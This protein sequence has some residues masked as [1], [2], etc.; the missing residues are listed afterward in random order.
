MSARRSIILPL[1]VFIVSGFSGYAHADV[2]AQ[3]VASV[4]GEKIS[5][6]ELR[7]AIGFWGGGVSASDIPAEKKTETLERLITGRL[8]SQ[9]ARSRGLDN[10]EEFRNMLRQGEHNRMISAMFR[11]EFASG[12]KITKEE[13]RAESAKLRKSDK[14]LTP[15]NANLKAKATLWKRKTQKVQEGLVD[16]AKKHS[17]AKIIEEMIENIAKGE[18]VEDNAVL[19]IVGEDNVSYGEFKKAMGAMAG[20]KHA[21]TDISANPDAIRNFLNREITGRSLVVY[22]RAQ[23][24]EDSEWMRLVRREAERSILTDM[25]MKEKILN[26]VDVTEKE[27]QDAYSKHAQMMVRDGKKIPL[28][29]VKGQIRDIVMQE[30]KKKAVDTY[31]AK[32]KKKAKIT[33]NKKLLPKV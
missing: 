7:E 28:S 21:G 12:V 22:A 10:T 23:R 24:I 30:K 4:N 8:L 9:D 18:K 32:L 33:V 19:A 25:L 14:D 20:A 27:I 3:A 17:S 6:L 5:V 31:V 26:K 1:V 16:A 2:K 15:E 11:K 13:L 29:E